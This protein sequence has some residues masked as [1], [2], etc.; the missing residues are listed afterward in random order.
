MAVSVAARVFGF[1]RTRPDIASMRG[2]KEKKEDHGCCSRRGETRRKQAGVNAGLGFTRTR[3]RGYASVRECVLPFAFFPS[4][5]SP[6][7]YSPVYFLLTRAMKVLFLII[8]EYKNTNAVFSGSFVPRRSTLFR[9][10]TSRRK[11][12]PRLFFAPLFPR[13]S[14]LEKANRYRVNIVFFPLVACF[15]LRFSTL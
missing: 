12:V 2:G 15:S 4:A 3:P 6:R 10:I 14:R 11:R 5:L 7:G 9:G 13:V 8:S 1:A